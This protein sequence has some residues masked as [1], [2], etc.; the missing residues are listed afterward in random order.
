MG[1]YSTKAY[2]QQTCTNMHRIVYIY[3]VVEHTYT[4]VDEF[5]W[6]RLASVIE[7]DE[8]D[9]DIDD[10]GDDGKCCAVESVSVVE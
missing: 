9:G 5:K 6:F 2:K 1:V 7:L 4:S 3:I 10:G 8:L